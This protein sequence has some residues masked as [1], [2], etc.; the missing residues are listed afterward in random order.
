MRF[1]K[2][3]RGRHDLFPKFLF[4]RLALRQGHAFIAQSDPADPNRARGRPIYVQGTVANA[5][6]D[7]NTSMYHLCDLPSDCILLE[8]TAFDVQ[9][10][11]FAQV[12]I[13]TRD[14]TDALL[15]V[16]KS[17]ANTQRPI[18]FGD[19]NHAKELWEVLGLAANP[20]GTIGLYAHAEADAAGAGSMPFQVVYSFR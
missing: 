11:G 16:A 17:A 18:T 3:H 15:D 13:G 10:W 20:G 7:S 14:D 6:T 9:N 2:H 12:V 5:A 19:A 8:H 1:K 4:T